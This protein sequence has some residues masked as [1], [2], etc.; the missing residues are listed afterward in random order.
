M[1][2]KP[3]LLFTQVQESRIQFLEKLKHWIILKEH[4]HASLCDNTHVFTQIRFK[5]GIPDHN[6]TKQK[7]YSEIQQQHKEQVQSLT[8]L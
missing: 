8:N 1:Q 3:Y 5:A 7:G 4:L 2:Q 6:R